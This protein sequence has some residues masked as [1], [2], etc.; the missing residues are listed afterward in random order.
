MENVKNGMHHMHYWKPSLAIDFVWYN[1][2]SNGNKY[3]HV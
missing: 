3:N 2:D 1:L